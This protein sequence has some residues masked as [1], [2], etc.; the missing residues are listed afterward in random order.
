MTMLTVK[1]TIEKTWVLK[2]SCALARHYGHETN[3]NAWRTRMVAETTGRQATLE[4]TE[5]PRRTCHCII[6]VQTSTPTAALETILNLHQLIFSLMRR[7]ELKQRDLN[8][9]LLVVM[10][11]K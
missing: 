8:V 11:S 1:R 6:C 9:L 2:P 4:I 5:I 10:I 3:D 7:P